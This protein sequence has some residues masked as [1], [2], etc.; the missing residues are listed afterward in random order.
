MHENIFHTISVQYIKQA[1]DETPV[2]T[3]DFK[4]GKVI[5]FPCAMQQF[6][7]SKFSWKRKAE[8]NTIR[9]TIKAERN[10]SNRFV[11]RKKEEGKDRDRHQRNQQDEFPRPVNIRGCKAVKSRVKRFRV[12]PFK[13]STQFDQKTV[14]HFKV[15]SLVQLSFSMGGLDPRD[16]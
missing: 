12:K 1:C 7:V 2:K 16:R 11:V 10:D 15:S 9:N 4:K 8:R 13:G 14:S 5:T 3:V 6:T